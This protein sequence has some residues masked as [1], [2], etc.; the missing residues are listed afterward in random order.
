MNSNKYIRVL[1]RVFRKKAFKLS[2]V[3]ISL[4]GLLISSGHSL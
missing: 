2:M 3:G 4:V 1:S